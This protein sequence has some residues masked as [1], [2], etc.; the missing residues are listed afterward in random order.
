MA[1]P[2]AFVAFAGRDG[3]QPGAAKPSRLWPSNLW[4][5]YFTQSRLMR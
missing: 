1:L 3:L 2:G 5:G 4:K